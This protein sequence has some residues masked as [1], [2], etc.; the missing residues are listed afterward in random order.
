MLVHGW[1]RPRAAGT[2]GVHGAPRRTGVAMD[3]E[4]L[5]K[6]VAEFVAA[7]KFH[8]ALNV[9]LSG[10]NA[11]RR[12]GDAAGVARCLALIRATVDDLERACRAEA[13][14]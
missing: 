2:M 12:A 3:H 6:Q 8:P 10:L 14:G 1:R 4:A 13:D 11:C 9:A 7:G 5:A